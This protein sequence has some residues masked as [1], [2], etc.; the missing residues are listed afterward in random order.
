MAS[1]APESVAPPPPLV[2]G[3][4]GRWRRFLSPFYVLNGERRDERALSRTRR[5]P[6]REWHSL[7]DRLRFEWC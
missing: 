2:L 3:P 5:F 7:V 4:G 6:R 1:T